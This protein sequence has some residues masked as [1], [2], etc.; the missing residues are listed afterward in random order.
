MS[1]CASPRCDA[2]YLCPACRAR[3]KSAGLGP[4]VMLDFDGVLNSKQYFK[5]F[6][7]AAT[8]GEPL[9]PRAVLR[10]QRICDET[11]ARIVISSSWRHYLS[12]AKLRKLLGAK[13]LTADIVGATPQNIRRRGL[14]IQEWL[15]EAA[16]T[17]GVS[18]LAMEWIAVDDQSAEEMAPTMGRFVQT[19]WKEGLTDALADNAIRRLLAQRR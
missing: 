12:V 13:G 6:P 3:V 19:T 8:T 16:V 9:D 17:A 11:G 1:E 10:V 7:E 4:Y 5:D 2:G 18:A 14:Q 15:E